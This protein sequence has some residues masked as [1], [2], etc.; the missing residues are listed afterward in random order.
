ML[1][2]PSD[3]DDDERDG[4]QDGDRDGRD[5]KYAEALELISGRKT[6]STSRLQ[7]MM[8]I[9]YNRAARIIDQMEADG[10]VGP[11][12]G[13]KPRQVLVPPSNHYNDLNL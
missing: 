4:E 8:G 12:N 11:A 2:P 10:V 9:G 13:S 6:I 3:D 1:K 7:R 5:S